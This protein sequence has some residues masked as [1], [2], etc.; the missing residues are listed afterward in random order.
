MT[1]FKQIFQQFKVTG[2][3]GIALPYGNGHINSTFLVQTKETTTPSYIMQKINHHVFPNPDQLQENFLKIS[4]HLTNLKHFLPD[5][6]DHLKYLIYY[7]TKTRKS[8]YVD[9]HGD[10][11]RIFNYIEGAESYD[12]VKNA[13]QAYQAG[14]I[15]GHFQKSLVNFPVSELH[16][17]IPHFHDLEWRLA[18][19]DEE[20]LR[21]SLDRNKSAELEINYVQEMREKLLKIH[22]AGK[23]GDIPFR[24]TH[25]DTKFNNILLNEND[26]AVSLIDLDTVMKGMVHFDFGDAIRSITNNAAE[27][28]EDLS[29]VKINL[30]YLE[31][32]I[33]GYFEE[34]KEFLT[35][36]ETRLLSEAPAMMAFML[37]VRFLTDYLDGDH[38]FAIHDQMQN[39][40]RVKVQFSLADQFLNIQPKIT[41]IIREVS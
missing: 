32:F 28:I 23:S 10:Y 39:L 41:H 29:R 24:V 19:F 22:F 21:N 3:Y 16:D 6:K 9:A 35:Q 17:I 2:T 7:P 12:L 18:N 15:I 13:N 4:Q 34:A 1:D 36:K 25:N 20:F 11:W 5:H 30:P 33:H 8:L 27:D 38:Y 26:Q 31:A 37:G 14:K 40:R